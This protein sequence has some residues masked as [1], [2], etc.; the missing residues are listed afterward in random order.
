MSPQQHRFFQLVASLFAAAW[1]SVSC[2]QAG[3]HYAGNP[4][5]AYLTTKEYFSK[6]DGYE[7]GVNAHQDLSVGKIDLGKKLFNDKRL[8]LNGTLACATCHNPKQHYT[9][10]NRTLPIGALS[11]SQGRNAPS[12]FDVALRKSFNWD[13]AKKSLQEQVLGPLLSA[14]EMNNPSMDA[15]ASRLQGLEDYRRFFA[16]AYDGEVSERTIADALSAY[17]VTLITGPNAFDEWQKDKDDNKLGTGELAGYNLFI[18][19]AGCS[20]CHT[21]GSKPYRFSDGDYH[22][23][24]YS[25]ATNATL[26]LG[27]MEVT[28]D[29]EDRFKFRTPTLRN[30]ALTSPYMHDGG[31]ATLE[32]VVEFFNQSRQLG[33]V[34]EEKKQLVAFLNALTSPQRP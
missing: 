9:Q 22:D 4:E 8:S 28:G 34:A 15:V 3:N 24:G 26:D 17:Q 20:A 2:Q 18:G 27:R 10:N 31:I 13:G 14:H 32:G 30:V 6:G 19:K 29:E 1:L 33:L 12:L 5:E 21:I 23:T 11:G 25:V 16:Y 7:A